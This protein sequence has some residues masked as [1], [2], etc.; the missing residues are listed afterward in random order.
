MRQKYTKTY[1]NPARP[2]VRQCTKCPDC[3]LCMCLERTIVYLYNIY[4]SKEYGEGSRIGHVMTMETCGH[5]TY[6]LSVLE[7]VV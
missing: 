3:V 7:G 4:R 1:I 5:V 2:D 6:S